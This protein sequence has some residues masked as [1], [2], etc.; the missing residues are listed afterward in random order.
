[1][2]YLL[3]RRRRLEQANVI[4]CNTACTN[5]TFFQRASVDSLPNVL[6]FGFEHECA[7]CPSIVLTS[8]QIY[9]TLQTHQTAIAC[10]N[11][12]LSD[13]SQAGLEVCTNE[14]SMAI[15]EVW[16]KGGRRISPMC[17]SDAIMWRQTVAWC[18]QTCDIRSI[19]SSF[20]CRQ[21]KVNFDVLS[22]LGGGFSCW[23][24]DVGCTYYVFNYDWRFTPI[25]VVVVIVTPYFYRVLIVVNVWMR[26][27]LGTRKI[28]SAI[29]LIDIWQ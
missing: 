10:S 24:S 6:Q 14:M 19:H 3:H 28:S 17:E 22:T 27:V 2:I 13:Q 21:C 8:K 11:F 1:M 15:D 7:V 5:M 23:C 25:Y 12:S 4:Q 20:W 18:R 29:S 16:T 26:S 9:P